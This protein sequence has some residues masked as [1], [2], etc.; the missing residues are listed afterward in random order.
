MC[1]ILNANFL[2]NSLHREVTFNAVI[3][4]RKN[5]PLKTLYL[6]HGIYGNYTNWITNTRAALWAEERGIAVIMPS[7]DNSFYLDNLNSS[8]MYADFF[9]RELVEIT[10]ELFPL[11]V[12]RSDTFIG[13]LSMG[14]YGA[15]RTG[16][17][18]HKTFGAIASMSAVLMPEK[19]PNLKDNSPILIT[20][21]NYFESIFG[22]LDKI[23]GSDNDPKTLI[24]QLNK[25]DIPEIYLCCGTKDFL[26]EH[27]RN[28]HAFLLEREIDHTYEEDIGTHDWE[29]WDRYILKVLDWLLS[30]KPLPV[31]KP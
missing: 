23:S 9:G 20:R 2:S 1:A 16:L 14:G 21:R 5:K 12:Q 15:M 11:S 4:V 10:R 8:A 24:S 22:D 29:F 3:P 25:T 6:L 30:D 13:G 18:Y 28:F 19:T 17:K 27:S 26:I 7:A 31:I